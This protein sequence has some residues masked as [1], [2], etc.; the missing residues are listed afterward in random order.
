MIPKKDDRVM[1]Q[2]N[3]ISQDNWREIR[4]YFPTVYH[5]PPHYNAFMGI[6]M[7]RKRRKINEN[8]HTTL[9]DK[10]FYMTIVISSWWYWAFP[11]IHKIDSYESTRKVP[12]LICIFYCETI[13]LNSFWVTSMNI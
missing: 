13:F 4:N 6:D 9:D 1:P 12:Y 2:K 5:Q 11:D 10:S 7:F 8:P 3:G